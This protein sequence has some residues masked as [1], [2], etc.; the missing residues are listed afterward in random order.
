VEEFLLRRWRATCREVGNGMEETESR[1]DEGREEEA[2][3][4]EKAR[5]RAAK[6]SSGPSKA[7]SAGPWSAP[8]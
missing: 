6:G 1:G 4:A 8:V 5:D 7:K 2:T 3:E